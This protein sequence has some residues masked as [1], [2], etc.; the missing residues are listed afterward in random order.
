MQRTQPR[1]ALS[2]LALSLVFLLPGC[3]AIPYEIAPDPERVLEPQQKKTFSIKASGDWRSSGVLVQK[4]AEY[5]ITASGRWRISSFPS[6]VGPDGIG[7][8]SLFPIVDGY[9]EA[10]LIAKIGDQPPFAVGNSF[11]LQPRS[12]GLPYFRINDRNTGDNQGQVEVSVENVTQIREALPPPAVAPG[13]DLPKMAVWDLSSGNIPPAYAQ[14]LTYILVSEINKLAKDEIYSQ[15]NVRTL[16]GWTAERMALGCT[17]SKCLTALGPID[18]AKLISGRI[19]KIGDTC[20][21][22]LS[23]FDT[24]KVGAERSISEFTRSENERIRLLQQGV[25][26]LLAPPP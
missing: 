13:R 16:A 9:T 6:W 10:T 1:P 25:R 12:D 20:S 23:L 19:G 15:E 24:Q 4:G 3:A 22:S 21:L 11:R 18:I 8:Q 7:T 26:K 5:Q 17:D 14:D 2:I